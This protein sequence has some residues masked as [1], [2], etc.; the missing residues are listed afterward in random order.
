MEDETQVEETTLEP[1]ETVETVEVVD[2]PEEDFDDI[3]ARLAK[4]EELAK[5]YKIR[6]EKAESKA[7]EVVVEKPSTDFTPAD[8]LALTKAG[9]EPE[10][11][12]EIIEFAQYKKI[13]IHEAIKSPVIKATLAEAEERRKSAQATH[14]ASARRGS[15]QV[16]DDQL[17]ANARK[18]VMPDSDAD[19]NRL[20]Q[21]RLRQR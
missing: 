12:D 3:K 13:P 14:T 21:L 9:I 2:E 15:A 10:D 1:Q 8:I 7:K 6:A 5:N 18:G 19:M 16:S 4:A 11:L 17:L 20:V